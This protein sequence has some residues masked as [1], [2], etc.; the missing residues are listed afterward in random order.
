MRPKVKFAVI[1]RHRDKYPISVMCQFF[2]V[3]RSGYYDFVKRA[4]QP[5]WDARLAKQIEACQ[6]KVDK[7]S[8]VAAFYEVYNSVT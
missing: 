5:A 6:H 4:G 7:I 2:G 8:C 1:H 3:S